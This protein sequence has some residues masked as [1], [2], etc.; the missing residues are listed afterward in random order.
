MPCEG[1]RW[2]AC[3]IHF[4]G[5]YLSMDSVHDLLWWWDVVIDEWSA[6][7]IGC[8]R[9]GNTIDTLPEQSVVAGNRHRWTCFTY[10]GGQNLSF[11]CINSL[12]SSTVSIDRHRPQ[13]IVADNVLYR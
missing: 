3:T 9:Q 10:C 12:L 2:I 5:Q 1:D 6:K 8:G 4:G 13:S 11:D 7:S